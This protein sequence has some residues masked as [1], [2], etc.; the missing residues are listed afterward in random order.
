M[1]DETFGRLDGL[2][3]VVT[4]AARGIG[5]GCAAALASRGARILLADLDERPLNDAVTEL[6]SGGAEV[7][8][9]VTDVRA[10]DSVEEMTEACIH[11]FG[12]IDFV[13]ANAGIGDYS[14]LDTEIR[15]GGA[16]SSRRTSSASCTRFE[17]RS[18]G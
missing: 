1:Q 9:R 13:V 2:A 8:G 12:G 15:N 11:A 18:R 4:G 14:T 6:S 16:G 7:A 3:G 10:W 5:K 17:R